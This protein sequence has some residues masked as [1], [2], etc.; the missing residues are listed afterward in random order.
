MKGFK[1]RFGKLM[2]NDPKSQLKLAA[3]LI[4]AFA[5]IVLAVGIIGTFFNHCFWNAVVSFLSPVPIRDDGNEWWLSLI[6]LIAYIVGLI[7]FSGISIATITTMIRTAGER[8]TNG[9]ARY[10]LNNHILFLGYDD[11]M[12]GT[13][14]NELADNPNSD[15]VVA[16]PGNVAEARNTIHQYLTNNQ[17]ERTIVIQA[18]RIKFDDLKNAVYVQKAQRIYIIG[19]PEEDTHDANNLKCLGLITGM[20]Y[21]LQNKPMCLYYMRN[22]ATF[23]LM[24]RQNLTVDYLHDDICSSCTHYDKSNVEEYLGNYCEPFNFYE[25]A[26][27]KLLFNLHD[28]DNSLKIDW[29]NAQN[30]LIKH[31]SLQPHLVIVG[32]S[33]MGTALAK[34]AL[35]A[36]HYPNK[37]L[38]ISFV[39]SNAYEEMHYFIGRYESFFN[40]CNYVY[41]N[42]D[43]SA[44]DNVHKPNGSDFLDVEFEFIQCDVAHPKLKEL[45]MQSVVNKDNEIMTIAVCSNDAPRNMAFVL[46]LNRAILENVPIWVY[47]KNNTGMDSFLDHSIYKQVRIFSLIDMAI[48][49]PDRSKEYELVKQ[50]AHTYDVLYGC[51]NGF[52]MRFLSLLN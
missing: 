8:F 42:L 46:Y 22:H 20:C 23:S 40:N 11:M 17:S 30:N 44:K 32:M 16:V 51:E 6:K 43:D 35:M 37:K 36:I 2:A 27:R 19:Q 33:E 5:V 14:R 39:D 1:Y 34:A 21:A 52:I 18:S 7:V 47:Q 25:S 3:Q 41:R 12:I 10:S 9:T 50:V 4:G 49:I 28:Y 24:Q 29:H 48:P 13:V 38:K 45:L 15:I 26:T 31:P